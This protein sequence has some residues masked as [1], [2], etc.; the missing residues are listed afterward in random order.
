[1]VDSVSA[2]KTDSIG[3][4]KSHSSISRHH[5]S[6]T[7]IETASVDEQQLRHGFLGFFVAIL[8]N[9]RRFLVYASRERPSP[10]AAFRNEA[11]IAE[12]PVDWHP[13]LIALVQSQAFSQFVDERVGRIQTGENRGAM[14]NDIVFFDESIDAKMNRYYFSLSTIDT[15]FLKSTADNHAKTYVPPSPDSNGLEDLINGSITYNRFPLLDP[16]FFAPLRAGNVNSAFEASTRGQALAA[17][18]SQARL[19][20]TNAVPATENLSLASCHWSCILTV[21]S[22]LIVTSSTHAKGIQRASCH[23]IQLEIAFHGSPFKPAS[24]RDRSNSQE[25]T[26]GYI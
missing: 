5:N 3:I 1:V 14:M 9:Y 7:S 8:K 26:V 13:F 20:R 18:A 25:C 19:K 4:F 23:D 11:F 17:A 12:H 21:L 16:V 6:F 15:P 22:H 24:S 10:L 2:L